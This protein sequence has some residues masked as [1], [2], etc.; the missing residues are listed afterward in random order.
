M[1]IRV[2]NFKCSTKIVFQVDEQFGLVIGKITDS[3]MADDGTVMDFAK[4]VQAAQQRFVESDSCAAL[5]TETEN[6]G[7][8]AT[9]AWHYDSDGYVK[10]GIAFADAVVALEAR[11]DG[12]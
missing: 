3:G 7:Y 11:C 4:V 12:E 8:P 10:M 1:F 9:D 2:L 6:F 5:V